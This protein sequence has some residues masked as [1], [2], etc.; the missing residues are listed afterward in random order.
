[1]LRARIAQCE[2]PAEK[3]PEKPLGEKLK[4]AGYRALGGG[5]AGATAMV[6][7]V[8]TLMWL[9]TTMNYQYRYGT[10]TMDA[11]KSLYKEGG[12]VR[13]Y[14]GV[15]PALVQGPV[16]RFG[17]TAAN[18]GVLALFESSESLKGT[19]AMIQTVFGS[20]TAASMR[21]LLV[22]VDTVKTIMQVEGTKGLPKLREKYR[23]GG[24]PVFYHGSVATM[25][26]TFVGHYPWFTVYNTLQA[27]LPQYDEKP[28][29]LA[30]NAVI[31]FVASLSS[32]TVSNSLRVVKTYRQTHDTMPYKEIVE[33]IIKED[34]YVGL[35]GRGL[36]TRLLANGMQGLMF[37]VLYKIFEE[38][39]TKR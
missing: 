32:D 14:R 37:S 24:I 27:S 13:F 4:A 35:F 9:R 5:A 25:M 31:G 6:L 17:D 23:A 21:V 20:A 29:K 12:I 26:A 28:K 36:K 22:P 3:K 33:N 16:S 2:A 10:S 8:T 34:G 1:M 7:Q 19:P 15:G 30:R 38:Q 11:L 39:F 18:A